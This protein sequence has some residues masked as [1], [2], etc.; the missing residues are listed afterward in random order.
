MEFLIGS[1]KR[2]E[3]FIKKIKKSD[4]IAL[5]THNDLDGLASAFL[6]EKV[7]PLKAI[8]FFSYKMN[9]SS[10]FGEFKKKKINKIIFTDV[11]IEGMKNEIKKAEKF[12]EILIIDHHESKINFNS[13]KTV[14]LKTD[15][16]TPA[17]LSCFE[18]FSKFTD[19]SRHDWLVALGI[20]S[21]FGFKK[22]KDFL[23]AVNRKY[24]L[25][26]SKEIIE[27][28]LGDYVKLLN[29]AII[30][31]NKNLKKLYDE[32]KKVKN[33][34]DLNKFK[35]FRK[36]IDKEIDAK[37]KEFEKKAEKQDDLYFYYF[38]QKYHIAS[39]VS[40]ILSRKSQGNTFIIVGDSGEKF[41]KANGRR[42]DGKKNL[43]ELFKKA[44]KGLKDAGAGGHIRAAGADIRR[45]DLAKFKKR[46]FEL[47]K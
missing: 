16:F 12:A 34:R 4:K 3:E 22:N 41:L 19:L 17:C 9:I 14:Y 8:K 21:D 40:N 29:G 46:L 37:V 6:V 38:H 25:K 26:E 23:I 44:V 5:I 27:S 45:E 42:Q 30:Y 11:A 31:F 2:F 43:P 24:G 36:V 15:T 1:E 47:Y 32:L 20:I 7:L 28:E 13:A 10:L 39:V 33:L 35:R 18:L